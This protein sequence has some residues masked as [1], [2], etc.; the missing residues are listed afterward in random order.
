M[1]MSSH[2]LHSGG[3]GGCVLSTAGCHSWGGCGSV[4]AKF[5][6]TSAGTTPWKWPTTTAP[7]PTPFLR[8]VCVGESYAHPV[9][10]QAHPQGRVPGW[11]NWLADPMSHIGIPTQGRQEM[12]ELLAVCLLLSREG[13]THSPGIYYNVKRLSKDAVAANITDVCYN[14]VSWK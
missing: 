6:G 4:K 10:P 13:R 1:R 9:P 14:N 11:S 7:K 3:R 2:P 5:P 12:E 8:M